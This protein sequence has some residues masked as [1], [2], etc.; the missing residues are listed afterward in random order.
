MRLGTAR[1]PGEGLRL[2]TVRRLPRGVRKE[3]YAKNNWFDLW[4]PELAPST[5][6]LSYAT[7]SPMSPARWTTFTRR[8]HSEMKKPATQRLIA[9]LAALS[10][11]T[12]FSIG[13]YCPDQERCHRSLLS[14][15]LRAAGA[16]MA[17]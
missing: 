2:G 4:L 11:Q 1:F 17:P 3:D 6:L 13:C 8:Y 16:R 5:T 10:H 7:K 12:D 9:M 15:L 14:E